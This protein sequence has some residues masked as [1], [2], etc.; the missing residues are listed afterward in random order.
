MST[1]IRSLGAPDRLASLG[2]ATVAVSLLLPWYG[3]T[4]AGGLVK[5]PAGTFGFVEA[6]LVLTIGG[7]AFLIVRSAYGRELPRPLHTGT[8]LAL[9]GAWAGVLIAYRILDRPDFE[10]LNVERVGLRYGIFVAFA[11][12]G[13][14]VVGGLRKRRE[15]L[16]AEREGRDRTE[17]RRERP[18]S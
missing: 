14:I 7:A 18:I 17:Q 2:V 15:E 12:A 9:A 10:P 5:T 1:L 16:A 4:F 8:L 6:A 3:V 11:G 13:L